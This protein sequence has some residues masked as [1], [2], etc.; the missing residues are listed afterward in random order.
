MTGFS[1]VE[2]DCL[3]L[4]GLAS[5]IDFRVWLLALSPSFDSPEE[6]CREVREEVRVS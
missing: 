4:L 3:W 2:R 5:G 6:D 1:R